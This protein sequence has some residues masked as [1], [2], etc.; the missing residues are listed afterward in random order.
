MFL[1]LSLCTFG[2]AGYE[3][4]GSL[5]TFIETHRAEILKL[6]RDEAISKYF[7]THLLGTYGDVANLVG[8]ADALTQ[9]VYLKQEFQR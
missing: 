5:E 9:G 7:A 6:D 8:F 2:A 4:V 3:L 1:G